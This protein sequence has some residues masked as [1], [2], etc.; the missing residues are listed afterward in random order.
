MAQNVVIAGASYPNVP[1]VDIPK[2][3]GGI[4]R[5]YDVHG[6][7]DVTENGI[8]DVSG[9]AS[10]NV[11]TTAYI[12]QNLH[13]FETDINEIYIDNKDGA[14]VPYSGWKA[15]DYIPVDNTSI[16]IFNLSNIWCAC[17]DVNKN[18]VSFP[19]EG[20]RVQQFTNPNIKFFRA[21]FADSNMAIF[22]MQKIVCG[23]VQPGVKTQTKTATANGIVYPD[24]EYLLAGVTVAIPVYDGSVS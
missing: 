11:Q 20:I 13:N 6:S 22:N 24:A 15:T 1:A 19:T 17:Y 5:F 18:F 9:Y 7:L 14:E 10:A 21:S 8:Y 12:S 16:Y 3:G 2:S 4:A 23:E